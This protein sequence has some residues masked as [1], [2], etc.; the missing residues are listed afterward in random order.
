MLT[1]PNLP[2]NQI[3]QPTPKLPQIVPNDQGDEV[4]LKKEKSEIQCF[5]GGVR[6]IPSSPPRG[7]SRSPIIELVQF[8][9]W[10]IEAYAYKDWKP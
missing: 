8:F 5:K 4:V 1:P 2:P 3:F 10:A 9:N 6:Q 7:R